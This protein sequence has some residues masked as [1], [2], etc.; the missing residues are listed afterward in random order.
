M[1]PIQQVLGEDATKE[2]V[3]ADEC[4]KCLEVV[5]T[6]ISELSGSRSAAKETIA[7][8]RKEVETAYN[9]LAKKLYGAEGANT[10]SSQGNMPGAGMGGMPGMPPGFDPNSLTP[11]Q[12]KQMEELMRN[13]GG[14]AGMGGMPTSSSSS[15][16]LD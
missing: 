11:E 3:G 7:N 6:I 14:G 9:P 8:W 5:N 12:M 10:S 13:M 4:A 1:L 2:K 16:D 15:A